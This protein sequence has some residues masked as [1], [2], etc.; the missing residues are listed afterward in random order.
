MSLKDQNFTNKLARDPNHKQ[1]TTGITNDQ[2]IESYCASPSVMMSRYKHLY[3]D[4]KFASITPDE[5]A[6]VLYRLNDGTI[7][8]SGAI[9]VIDELE[10][11]NKVFVNFIG[12][13]HE[14]G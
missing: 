8:K 10:R 4:G 1:W 14:Q 7:N 12:T 2:I 5:L 6:A 13:L 9:K 3:I 11:R